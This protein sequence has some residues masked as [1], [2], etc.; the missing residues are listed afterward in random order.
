MASRREADRPHRDLVIKDVST[1]IEFILENAEALQNQSMGWSWGTTI[2]GWYT[3]QNNDKVNRL[4][5]YAP[6]WISL[7]PAA[8]RR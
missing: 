2:M 3:A 4:V 1:V 5:L 8:Q 7:T 6:S